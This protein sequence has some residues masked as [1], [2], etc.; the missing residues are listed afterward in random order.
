VNGKPKIK[1]KVPASLKLVV[2]HPRQTRL[3]DVPGML[4]SLAAQI[5]DGALAA[6]KRI[7]WVSQEQNDTYGV[8]LI[9]E[10]VPMQGALG[11]LY[12]GAYEL[13]I[14]LSNGLSIHRD[15]AA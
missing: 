11:I 6:P 14:M 4:R 10:Y 13:T 15:P 9:G 12:C 1:S 3:N 8:G 5:E 7:V 2:P